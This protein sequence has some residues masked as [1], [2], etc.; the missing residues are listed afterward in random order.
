MINN[1]SVVSWLILYIFMTAEYG[2]SQ[3]INALRNGPGLGLD[4]EARVATSDIYKAL[5]EC[6][7]QFSLLKKRIL[8][9]TTENPKFFKDSRDP[10]PL[11][12]EEQNIL[13]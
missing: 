9:K 13:E 12:P 1:G 4:F 8:E 7:Q 5:C 10:F 11:F 6:Q 3:A 2:E